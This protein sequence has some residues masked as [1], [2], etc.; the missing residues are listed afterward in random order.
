MEDLG[1]SHSQIKENPNFNHLNKFSSCF[2]S[3][4][5]NPLSSKGPATLHFSRSTICG[6]HNL[7]PRL[8][9][10]LLH[11]CSYAWKLSH[12][13]DTYTLLESSLQLRHLLHQCLQTS[14]QGLCPCQCQALV[15]FYDL[16]VPSKPVPPVWFLDTIKSSCQHEIQT[17]QACTTASVCWRTEKKKTNLSEDVSSIMLGL[18]LITIDFLVLNYHNKI[19]HWRKDF[20]LPWWGLL[21]FTIDSSVIADQIHN[22]MNSKLYKMAPIET[23][24]SSGMSQSRLLSSALH[25]AFLSKLP[26]N[27]PSNFEHSRA[28][29]AQSSKI[30]HNSPQT[31]MVVSVTAIPYNLCLS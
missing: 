23:L 10:A 15:V 8:R 24:L 9:P 1:H 25:L 7:S 30:F 13:T 21:I 6:I 2:L 4:T 5:H 17:W 14:I 19:S 29:L 18:F 28:Y 20:F 31:N 22:I 11:S 27:F 3:S 26:Q 16:L 12:C